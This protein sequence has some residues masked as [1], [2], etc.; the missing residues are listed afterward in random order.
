MKH[1][2]KFKTFENVNTDDW[3]VLF[4]VLQSDIFDEWDI[5][6]IKSESFDGSEN[7]P[8]YKVWAFRTDDGK[9]SGE[10]SSNVNTISIYNIPLDESEHFWK[11]LIQIK[12]FLSEII[13]SEIVIIEEAVFDVYSDSHTFNDYYIKLKKL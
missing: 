12:L 11:D 13:S 5:Q 4:D 9:L 6:K 3:G 10:L 1:L 7:D 8:D 2:S